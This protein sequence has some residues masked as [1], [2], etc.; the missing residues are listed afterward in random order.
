MWIDCDRYVRKTEVVVLLPALLAENHLVQFS[1]PALAAGREV[2]DIPL[3]RKD[4]PSQRYDHDPGAR[5]NGHDPA[6]GAGRKPLSEQRFCLGKPWGGIL[7]AGKCFIGNASGISIGEYARVEFGKDFGATTALKLI[8]YHRVEFG[9]NVLI[10]WDTIIM[11]TD[12]HRMKNRGTGAYTKGYAP[13]HIGANCWIGCRS[14]I[15]KGTVLP[16]YCTL[17]AGT[18]I[19]KRIEGEYQVIGN[20]SELR[21]LKK[22]YFRE[23][24]DDEIEYPANF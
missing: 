18:T 13:V 17:G 16:A 20:T 14:T 10:G 5:N 22:D 11:D 21:T 23:V 6:G 4:S 7:F 1:L 8:S 19:G 24:G 15:L 3:S 2:A 9:Q 12:F